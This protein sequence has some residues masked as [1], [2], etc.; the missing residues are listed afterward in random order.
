MPTCSG[1]STYLAEKAGLPVDRFPSSEEEISRAETV[2]DQAIHELSIE[3]Q[4]KII[5]DIH[6]IATVREEDDGVIRS[7]MTGLEKEIEK[8]ASKEAYDFA[9]VLN[10]A[11]VMGHDFRMMFLRACNFNTTQAAM[12]IVNHFETKRELFGDDALGRDIWQSVRA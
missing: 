6:G 8:I 5:F 7:S 4:E 9:M 3:E 10:R 12:M 1:I 2:L 11:Y